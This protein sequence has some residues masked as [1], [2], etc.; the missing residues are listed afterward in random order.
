M[1]QNSHCIY[2]CVFITTTLYLLLYPWCHGAILVPWWNAL[3]SMFEPR[4]SYWNGF[5]LDQIQTM[6]AG[7]KH[8]RGLL[9]SNN[10]VKCGAHQ[11]DMDLGSFL[12]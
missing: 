11:P 5:P 2:V 12:F 4:L 10:C 1:L 9:W 6:A 8:P 3:A 7:R